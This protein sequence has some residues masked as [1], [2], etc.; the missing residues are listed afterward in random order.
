MKNIS[1]FF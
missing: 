1:S